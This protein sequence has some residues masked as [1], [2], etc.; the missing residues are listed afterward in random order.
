MNNYPFLPIRALRLVLEY[1]PCV[2]VT[3][4]EEG[5]ICRQCKGRATSTTTTTT[6]STGTLFPKS[7]KKKGETIVGR[8]DTYVET[9]GAL[10]VQRKYSFAIWMGER[11]GWIVAP[12]SDTDDYIL[13]SKISDD[14]FTVNVLQSHT[15]YTWDGSNFRATPIPYPLVSWTHH[16]QH[17]QHYHYSQYAFGSG[18]RNRILDFFKCGTD[19]F[20]VKVPPPSSTGSQ[21]VF[22]IALFNVKTRAI[23]TLVPR[24]ERDI[25]DTLMYLLGCIQESDTCAQ[26][27]VCST[28]HPY[29][30]YRELVCIISVDIQSLTF[31]LIATPIK[32]RRL[33]AVQAF[34]IHNLSDY[35]IFVADSNGCI[36]LLT[37]HPTENLL[38]LHYQC[39]RSGAWLFGVHQIHLPNDDEPTKIRVSHNR[40]HLVTDSQILFSDFKL[41]PLGNTPFAKLDHGFLNPG[42]LD[43]ELCSGD[44]HGTL[45]WI[46][47]E[48]EAIKERRI[49]AAS[50]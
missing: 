28:G 12:N 9:E 3:R 49:Q 13:L 16:Y 41:E 18:A 15:L 19:C 8:V 43:V 11:H 48:I 6:T 17:F 37:Y 2:V 38:D 10:C 22:S 33:P 29:L 21:P 25:P 40:I 20:L 32:I 34:L 30:P 31:S 42:I 23:Q 1:V 26:F 24:T 14:A 45:D 44:K 5:R 50:R 47:G 27:I 4:A 36:C 46:I 7:I 35:N 39:S